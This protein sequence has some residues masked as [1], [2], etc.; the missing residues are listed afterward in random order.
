MVKS[1]YGPKLI[2][3]D[4]EGYIHHLYTLYQNKVTKENYFLRNIDLPSYL[5]TSEAFTELV[6]ARYG[7][8]ISK[9]QIIPIDRNF[10]SHSYML[11]AQS[12][13]ILLTVFLQIKKDCKEAIELDFFIR[14]LEFAINFYKIAEKNNLP[15]F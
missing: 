3:K 8:I 12:N 6:I 15:L 11:R 13:I 4:N 7:N 10:Q 5:R 1:I 14:F 2:R 9:M